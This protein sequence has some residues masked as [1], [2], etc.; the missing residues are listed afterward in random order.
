[1]EC[2][3]TFS[4]LVQRQ[5]FCSG[6]CRAR[7]KRRRDRPENGLRTGVIYFLQQGEDGPVK[8][9]FSRDSNLETRIRNLQCGNPTKLFL[10]GTIMGIERDEQALHRKYQAYRMQGEWFNTT[11]V[12]RELDS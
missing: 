3:K 12:L 4:A 6:T 11:A 5:R 1:M 7:A 10:R 9:G 2:R 8:I